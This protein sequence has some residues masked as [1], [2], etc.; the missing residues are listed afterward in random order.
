MNVS[1]IRPNLPSI[2]TNEV[3]STPL[4][5]S[6]SAGSVEKTF[7]QMLDSL[8]QTQN[9][10]DKLIQQMAAG[11]EVDVHDAMIATEETEINFR[12]ALG[13]RDRL[14]DAYR[15]IMRMSI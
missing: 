13:I 1:G 6:G 8:S 4:Q 5:P 10:S 3:R 15:E 14:V 7:G 12:I 9:A 2:N 11:E